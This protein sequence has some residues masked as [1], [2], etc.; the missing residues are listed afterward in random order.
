MLKGKEF[1]VYL[2]EELNYRFF[3][4]IPFSEV[5][6][7]YKNMDSSIMHYVP[8]AHEEIAVKLATGAWIAGFKSAII[9]EPKK[10]TS[11]SINI[12]KELNIPLLFITNEIIKS[13]DFIISDN[14]DSLSKEMSSTG[15]SGIL[16]WGQET[17]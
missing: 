9:L 6:E 10:I 3:T 2:C 15:R 1:W 14:I 12:N 16:I 11:I 5:T 8:A 7:L 13:K 4:G 17:R